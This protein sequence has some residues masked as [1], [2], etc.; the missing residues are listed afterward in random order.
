MV[1]I[2]VIAA[3]ATGIVGILFA[4]GVVTPPRTR[5]EDIR[6]LRV[7][8]GTIELTATP[9][10]RVDGRFGL[11]FDAE[12]GHAKIGEIVAIT[13]A[14]VT[15]R[16][17]GVDF[18]DLGSARRGRFSGWFYLSPGELG[19]DYSDV[20]IRTE[21]G[22]APAWLIPP[23]HAADAAPSPWVIQV[24]GRGTRRSETLRAVGVFRSRGYTSLLVSYRNDGEAPPTGDNRYSLGDSEWNDVSAAIEFAVSRG[25]ASILLMGWSMGG[26]TVLQAL[27]RSPHATSIR[28]IALESP[29][30][31][32]RTTLEYQRRAMRL[33]KA[34]STS[35]QAILTHDWGNALTGQRASLDL[36]RLDFVTRAPELAVPILLLHS[37][38][39]GYVPPDASVKL[40]DAR[41]DLVTFE[42]F[43]T[44]RHTK[45]W[46]FDQ[47]RW[48][49]AIADWL[50]RIGNA[51]LA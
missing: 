8:A 27:T 38:D 40:A 44:A 51:H 35:A 23:A 43:T 45:L 28:A 50:D 47:E 17:I 25:A 19:F 22:D 48:E 1:A 49:T 33:T 24:H 16:V 41:P 26:A 15:R 21:L 11:W 10:T 34:V 3:A 20:V 42:R 4:R 7:G 46:N 36:D 18:G 6:I 29:V 30:V 13:D 39:D 5:D 14:T 2:G 31:D 37:V 32:W 9:D 12:S